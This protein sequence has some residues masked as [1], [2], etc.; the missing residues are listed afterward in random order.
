MDGWMDGWVGGWMDGWMDDFAISDIL[1]SVISVVQLVVQL[2]TCVK[3][4]ANVHLHSPITINCSHSRR[5]R[6]HKL[7]SG[8]A[9]HRPNVLL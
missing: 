3:L 6:H 8:G 9:S 5:W 7:Q 2:D 1:S 4:A